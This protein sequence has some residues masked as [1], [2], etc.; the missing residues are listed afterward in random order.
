MLLNMMSDQLL[1]T[2]QSKMTEYFKCRECKSDHCEIRLIYDS[3]DYLLCTKCRERLN[4]KD[5][6]WF[7]MKAEFK[8]D[9][10]CYF[11]DG[12]IIDP[13]QPIDDDND[14]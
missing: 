11:E 2:D 10:L 3:N 14:E 9:G 8:E 12:T 4:P 5:K 1:L 7:G 13:S 6:N